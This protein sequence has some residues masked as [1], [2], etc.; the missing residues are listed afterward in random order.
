MPFDHWQTWGITYPS[1]KPIRL[2]D[3]FHGKEIVPDAQSDSP[4]AHFCVIPFLQLVPRSRAQHLPSAFPAQRA[5]DSMNI[6]SQPLFLLFFMLA[7]FATSTLKILKIWN[8]CEVSPILIE[9]DLLPYN[10]PFASGEIKFLLNYSCFILYI[11]KEVQFQGDIYSLF[12]FCPHWAAAVITETHESERGLFSPRVSN[13]NLD[14]CNQ[15]HSCARQFT[16]AGCCPA[17]SERFGT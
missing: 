11:S 2:F 6:V 4:L 9:V 14:L 1:K 5:A 12:F 8:F 7:F 13:S 17:L 15:H 3:H 16:P 10:T